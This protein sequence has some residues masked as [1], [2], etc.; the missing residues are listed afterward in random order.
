MNAATVVFDLISRLVAYVIFGMLGGI[1]GV[2]LFRRK[3]A[4]P[5]TQE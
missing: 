4:T 2:A 3:F 5:T 1:L